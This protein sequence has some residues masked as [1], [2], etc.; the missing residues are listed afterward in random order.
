MYNVHLGGL[1]QPK[2]I[3]I[4]QNELR[5]HCNVYSP[6]L[7]NYS[8][9]TDIEKADTVAKELTAMEQSDI[10]VFYFNE[11]HVGTSAFLELGD[12]TGRDKIVIVCLDGNVKSKDKI[13]RYCEFRGI[14]VTTTIAN[15]I[16]AI[17]DYC[18]QMTICSVGEKHDLAA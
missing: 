18:Q 17:K 5:A 15:L 4:A 14:V 1:S 2:W 13:Q 7:N 11:E 6:Y 12:C 9:L 16:I 8:E 10:I 3:E